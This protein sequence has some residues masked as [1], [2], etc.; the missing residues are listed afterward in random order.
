MPICADIA[1]LVDYPVV[2]SFADWCFPHRNLP[3]KWASYAFPSNTRIYAT[4]TADPARARDISCRITNHVE[5]TQNAHMVPKAEL[6]WHDWNFMSQ[7]GV[8]GAV[9]AASVDDIGNY[10]L[11]RNDVHHIFDSKCFA[12]VPKASTLLVHLTALRRNDE[13][14]QLYHNVTLQPLVG[15]PIEYI[16]AR[17]A[18]TVLPLTRAFTTGGPKRWLRI[19]AAD[20]WKL[21]EYTGTKCAEL[22]G[23]TRSRSRSP[24]KRPN[25]SVP[26]SEDGPGGQGG[27][28][29]VRGRDRRPKPIT[30]WLEDMCYQQA[31][32]TS[33]EAIATADVDDDGDYGQ[34][35]YDFHEVDDA[36]ERESKGQFPTSI[37]IRT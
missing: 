8:Q 19:R 29:F 9:G 27:E 21:V 4:S 22:P 3:E 35:D 2:P 6:Q 11:L 34:I 16:F 26:S 30:S 14:M 33:G 13:L 12:I 23:L 31:L 28:V 32:P 15:I 10:I 20:G 24:R 37:T 17:F 36:E 18:W 25:P 5:G 7:Y 1:V